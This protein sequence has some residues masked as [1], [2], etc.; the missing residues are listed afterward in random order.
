[1][2]RLFDKGL[3][4]EDTARTL[5][6]IR[7]QYNNYI[8][9]YLRSSLAKD[10]FESR[11][12]FAAKYKEN[13]AKFFKNE[14]TILTDLLALEE[15][16]RLEKEHEKELMQNRRNR[17]KNGDFADKI[18]KD[19]EERIKLYPEVQ[20]TDKASTEVRKLYGALKVF[21]DRYWN[22]I[23]RYIKTATPMGRM[24][25][26]LENDLWQLVGSGTRNPPVLDK[27]IFLLE[28]PEIDLKAISYAEQECM[29]QVAFFTN[30]LLDLYRTSILDTT[31]PGKAVDGY[32]YLSQLVF[33]FRLSDIKKN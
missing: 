14:I 29:K 6:K 18:L 17:Q 2:F 13:M 5:K 4:K 16:K 28:R 15:N 25:D 20:I 27:Y 30:E 8:I 26:H 24:I 31:A 33:N 23:S 9:T 21:E 10:E 11:Y 7:N 19:L 22:H 12:Y 1:M 32:N 3:S